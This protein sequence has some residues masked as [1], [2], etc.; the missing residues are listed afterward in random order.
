MCDYGYMS[1]DRSLW[2]SLSVMAAHGCSC[3][4]LR[5]MAVYEFS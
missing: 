3:V 5:V 1:V 2:V 4:S